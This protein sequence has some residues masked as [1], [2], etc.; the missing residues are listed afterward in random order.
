M[1]QDAYVISALLS[2]PLTTRDTIPKALEIYSRIRLPVAYLVFERSR[3]SGRY[4]GFYDPE[5]P[6]LESGAWDLEKL[7]EDLREN[8]EW[9]LGVPHPKEA[10]AKA[11]ALLGQEC[12][13]L[14]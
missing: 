8:R 9:H 14:T 1:I 5:N 13:K 4:C 2:S 6:G 3:Q 12:A 7:A 10:M 11:L